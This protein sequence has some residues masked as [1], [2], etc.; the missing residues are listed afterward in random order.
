MRSW[1]GPLINKTG[2]FISRRRDTRV[3]FFFWILIKRQMTLGNQG[4]VFSSGT[5]STSTFILDFPASLTVR[6]YFAVQ[7]IQ[8]VVFVMAAKKAKTFNKLTIFFFNWRIIISVRKERKEKTVV[9]KI[10][11]SYA[12]EICIRVE[13]IA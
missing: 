9:N 13:L 6:K 8:S 2:V 1:G 11:L 12:F 5:K 7:T 4:R 3:Q 10:F